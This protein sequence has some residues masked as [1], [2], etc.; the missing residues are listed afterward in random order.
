MPTEIKN[1]NLLSLKA[2]EQ[3]KRRSDQVENSPLKGV[4]KRF[5]GA[6]LPFANP[7]RPKLDK[8]GDNYEP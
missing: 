2:Y 1:I 6:G 4:I 3:D 7:P 5:D 8:N